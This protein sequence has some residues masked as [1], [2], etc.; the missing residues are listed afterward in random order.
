MEKLIK[1][2]KYRW[3]IPRHENMLVRGLIFTDEIFIDYIEKENVLAQVKNV[4]HLPG[5]V[6]YSLA[7]PDIHWGYGF[8]IGGVAATRMDTG[9][10]SP[11]GVGYDINCGVRVIKTGLNY[12][13]IKNKTH[14]LTHKLF[15]NIPCGVGE[16]GK[17]RLNKKEE[18]KVLA[19]GAG[20]AVQNGYGEPLDL[21]F[22]EEN[23]AM[24]K[25]NPD[26]VSARA[27]ERGLSQL[28]TLG[29]G[30]HFIEIQYVEEIYDE[31][32]ANVLGLNLSQVLVMLHTGSR[33]LGYQVC[34][35]YIRVMHE[36]SIKQKIS[37]PDR[38]LACAYVKSNEGQSYFGAMACAANYA[39][40]NRQCITHWI[41][42]SFIQVLNISPRDLN[43]KV[44][45]DVSHNIAKIEEHIV[46]SE[47][48][49]LCIHRKGATR[50]FGPEDT[51]IPLLYKN[52]GQP[53]LI[54]GDMGRNSY[55]LV[56]TKKAMEETF[57][58]TCHGAGRLMSRTSALKQKDSQSIIKDM[59]EKNIYLVAREKKTIGEEAT[60]AYKDVNKI[61]DIVHGAGISKKVARLKPVGVIKG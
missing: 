21:D 19:Q 8:P 25:A 22:I 20:W 14:E 40:A 3:E 36:A 32:A 9:V 42:E 26:N 1:I 12:D 37:L 55:I 28:G 50:A 56:G 30:N 38:Q 15:S 7:M 2:D 43:I 16:H 29:A 61:V 35:D 27:K 4:A 24:D 60:Y 18:E 49:N 51:R 11:G 44:L 46:N 58:S 52:I 13:E 59:E 41:K 53:V 23:G 34:D 6:S 48:L 31:D 47:K 17:I 5:I 39:W 10:I 57:G 33:G 54:P 45:Y